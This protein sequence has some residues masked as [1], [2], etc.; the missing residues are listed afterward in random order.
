MNALVER[1]G[2]CGP[3]AVDNNCSLSH[4]CEENQPV[5]H[6]RNAANNRFGTIPERTSDGS[7]AALEGRVQAVRDMVSTSLFNKKW[8]PQQP[9]RLPVDSAGLY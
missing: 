8:K 7:D 4:P 6:M 5:G 9:L 2:W 3:N 1:K